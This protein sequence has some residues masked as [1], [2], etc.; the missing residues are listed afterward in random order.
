MRLFI[1]IILLI[2]TSEIS[3]NFDLGAPEIQAV[4]K[5]TLLDGNTIEGFITFGS[6]GAEY[7]YRPHGF[8]FA[9]ANGTKQLILYNLNFSSFNP[10]K[11]GSYRDGTSKL[12]Y[13]EHISDRNYEQL[14]TDYDE[15]SKTLKVTKTATKTYRLS[16][17]MTIYKKLPDDLYVGYSSDEF[18]G[19]M[20]IP[21]AQIMSVELLNQPSQ[22]SLNIIE[23]ARKNQRDREKTEEWVDYQPP[24][25]YHEIITDKETIDYLS[26]FF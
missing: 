14:K 12:Y 11:F 19:K 6:G 4:C 8:C 25:W 20:K 17:E 24:V 15:K 7:T 5:V 26:K 1:S 2:F 22:K 13:V 3:T 10:N 16:E 9:H 18:N 21:M 23:T